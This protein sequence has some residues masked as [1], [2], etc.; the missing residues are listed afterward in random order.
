M[1]KKHL[2]SLN[3]PAN[4]PIRR[5]EKTWVTR[6]NPG[7]HPLKKCIPLTLLVTGILKYAKTAREARNILKNNEVMINNRVVKEPKFSVGV[8]DIIKIKST[9]ESFLLFINQ[10]NK[11]ELKKINEE[12]E[13]LKLCKIINK[14]ILRKG[15]IQINFYDGRNLIVDKDSYKTGDTLILDLEKNKI[16]S[17]LKLEKN[18]LVYLVGGKYIGNVGKIEAITEKNGLQPSKISIKMNDRTIE[19]LKEY[20]FVINKELKL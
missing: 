17:H 3:A 19:T 4:W 20:A 14:K 7:P 11:Y 15:V 8:F 2:F 12:E 13:K 6:P 5:K 16:I 1:A 10:K 18:A 9:N